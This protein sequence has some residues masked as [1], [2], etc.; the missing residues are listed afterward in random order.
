MLRGTPIR[1]IEFKR[2]L[3]IDSNELPNPQDA[4]LM[5]VIQESFKKMVE[6]R[7]NTTDAR[8]PAEF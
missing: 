8:K 5:Q 7:R 6:V 3:G 4:A 2:V 1:L